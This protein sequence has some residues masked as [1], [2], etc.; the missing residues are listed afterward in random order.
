MQV[1]PATSPATGSE[2][3]QRADALAGMRGANCTEHSDLD[4]ARR[5]GTCV[6]R[7]AAWPGPLQERPT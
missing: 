3:Q 4:R 6:Y 5:E 7:A 2:R 1:G